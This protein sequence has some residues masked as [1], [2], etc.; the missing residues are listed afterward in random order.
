M[1]SAF[2]SSKAISSSSDIFFSSDGLGYSP[3]TMCQTRLLLTGI[4]LRKSL[5]EVVHS[6]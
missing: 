3:I 6:A 5:M 1:A 2:P 4:N